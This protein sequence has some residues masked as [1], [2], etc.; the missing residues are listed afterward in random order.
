M[1]KSKFT[2]AEK[3][4]IILEFLNTNITTAELQKTQHCT[5]DILSMERQIH[6]RW[7]G[8][9]KRYTKRRYLQEF[10]KGK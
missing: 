9:T 6:C 7:Q 5:T 8:I 3:S 10:T 4:R 1:V 2:S